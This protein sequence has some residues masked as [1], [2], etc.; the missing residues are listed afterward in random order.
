MQQ[1]PKNYFSPQAANNT[2]KQQCNQVFQ[3]QSNFTQNSNSST[4]QFSD[5]DLFL[6]CKYINPYNQQL[7]SSSSQNQ[8]NSVYSQQQSNLVLCH[9][10]TDNSQQI[11]QAASNCSFRDNFCYLQPQASHFETQP[12]NENFNPQIQSSNF[13]LQPQD[14]NFLQQPQNLS[15]EQPPNSSFLSQSQSSSYEQ[16]QNSNILQQPINTS[17][18]QQSQN[19]NFGQ[20][21]QNLSFEQQSQNASFEQQPQ[22]TSFCQQ[23][24][25]SSFEQQSQN[26]S[27]EQKQ[28]CL[29]NSPNVQSFSESESFHISYNNNEF[30]VNPFCLCKSSLLFDKLIHP[31]IK[32]FE[33]MKSI[34]LEIFGNK[35]SNRNMTNFLL[36]CQNQPTD[37]QDNEIKEICEIAKMFKAEDIYYTGLDFIRRSIDHNFYVPDNKYDGSDGITYLKIV[38]EN[39]NEIDE[40]NKAEDQINKEEVGNGDIATKTEKVDTSKPLVYSLLIELPLLKCP[41]FRFLYNEKTLFTAKKR[42]NEVFIAKGDEVHISKKEDHVAYIK[43][44][45][46]SKNNT[47]SINN[48]KF[49]VNYKFFREAFWIDASF[50]FKNG[51]E[52]LTPVKPKYDKKNKKYIFD[53]S[54]AYHHKSIDS[55]RN[56]VLQSGNGNKN[57]IVR[58]V[59]KYT[60][61]IECDQE[62]DPLI[63]FTIAISEIIG[64]YGIYLEK[65]ESK[66][67]SYLNYYCFY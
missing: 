31:Y 13:E 29:Y 4:K 20:Q 5:E 11:Q 39:T 14:V 2:T 33:Q 36:L 9:Y 10:A 25:N 49:T 21:S 28:Q 6:P 24:L 61:E 34:H 66:N 43:Q 55:I 62:L 65:S 48:M 38:R 60:F 64:P 3:Q 22:N 59:L 30:I 7:N 26:T 44:N 12:Q 51:V 53:L 58:K 37:I 45:E 56:V 1:Q 35:F 41:L 47:V 42:D 57:F 27:F 40:K 19:A 52:H 18:G 50:P 17:F 46:A 32:D 54:G 16:S 67:N 15:F 63:A 8:I 23:P